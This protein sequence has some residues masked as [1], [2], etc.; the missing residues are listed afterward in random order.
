VDS[1]KDGNTRTTTGTKTGPAGTSTYNG[2]T[3]RNPGEV[4]RTQ[5]LTGPNGGV[6]SRSADTKLVTPTQVERTVIRDL[7]KPTLEE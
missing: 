3:V 5:T 7:T 4:S 2:T 1:V 6:R